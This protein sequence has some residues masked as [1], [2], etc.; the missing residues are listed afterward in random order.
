MKCYDDI[1]GFL[2]NRDN[3]P[4]DVTPTSPVQGE[5][6][7]LTS[8]AASESFCLCFIHLGLWQ[9]VSIRC[10]SATAVTSW[11]SLLLT[12]E[13]MV[14][15]KQTYGLVNGQPGLV[16]ADP[17]QSR[18]NCII[19]NR[20]QWKTI[21]IAFL[22]MQWPSPVC[23]QCPCCFCLLLIHFNQNNV[24]STEEWNW[25]HLTENFQTENKALNSLISDK[26][27]E[28]TSPINVLQWDW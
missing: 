14:N 12:G 3:N 25:I 4:D 5:R 28:S 19:I 20:K 10:W 24:S 1:C 18:Q 22:R 7:K 17:L 15:A 27:V 13:F 21:K 23:S 2:G 16:Q 6:R 8:G 11:S 9:N 26:R